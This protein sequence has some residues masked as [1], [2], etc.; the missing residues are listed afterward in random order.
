MKADA[1]IEFIQD[2]PECGICKGDRA[3]ALVDCNYVEANHKDIGCW[4]DEELRKR[5]R[6][7]F[8]C[9]VHYVICN[10]DKL[11]LDLRPDLENS[12]C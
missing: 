1:Q 2:R 4:L 3:N 11:I 6:E 9:D 12:V 10:E 7:S 5:Y 8:Y